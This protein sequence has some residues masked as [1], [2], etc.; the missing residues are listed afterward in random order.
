MNEIETIYGF[1]E[2]TD[3]LRTEP[4]VGD[5]Y[6]VKNTKH[7]YGICGRVSW[8]SNYGIV[9]ICFWLED[10]VRADAIPLRLYLIFNHLQHLTHHVDVGKNPIPLAVDNTFSLV[11]IPT[12]KDA[13]RV[14]ALLLKHELRGG[15]DQE[16]FQ[17]SRKHINLTQVKT[18]RSHGYSMATYQMS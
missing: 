16:N 9:L 6:V 12:G 11:G 1:I 14:K 2:N 8:T 3:V 15:D 4:K 18:G 5:L 10:L 13:K 7:P 17:V